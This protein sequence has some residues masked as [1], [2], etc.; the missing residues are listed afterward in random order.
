LT[1]PKTAKNRCHLDLQA[2]SRDGVHNEVARLQ[3]LG[4]KVIRDPQEEFGAYW[5]TLQDPEENEF[6]IGAR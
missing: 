2:E 1:E 4:A 5:S 6:C 3:S